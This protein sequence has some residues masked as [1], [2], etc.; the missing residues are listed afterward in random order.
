MYKPVVLVVLDG[1]GISNSIQGNPIRLASL[2]TIEKLDRF[3]PMT[4]LQASG[5]SVGLPWGETGNSEVGHMALGA[6]KIIYQNLPRITLAIQDQSFF[7]NSAFLEA[8]ENAKRMKSNLHLIGLFGEGSVHSYKDHVYALLELA[9]N[10]KMQDVYLHIFTDGRDSPPNS[11]TKSIKELLDK[12]RIFNVGKIASVC[13]RNWAMDRNNNWDRVEK[14]YLL[15]TEGKGEKITDPIKYLQESY[16]K[17]IFDEYIEPGVVTENGNPVAVIKD[18]DSVIF[19][20]FREDRARE[21][22][23]A[24]V[25]PEFAGFKRT[26]KLEIKFIT[27]IEY[28]KGLPVSTAFPPEEIREGL[29]EVLSKNNIAQLRIAETEKYA[30]VTYFF[31]GGREEPWPA[32]DRTLIPSPV[33][34]HFDETPEMSAPQITEKSVEAIESG[35]YGFIL[36]NYANPDMIGH[37]GNEKASIEAVQAVDK[38]LSVLI[39]SILKAGGC[40]ILTSDH[41][42]VEEIKNL[43]TGQTDTE[44]SGNPV[45]IWYITPDNHRNKD[46]DEI[47]RNQNEVGGLL[48]DVAPTI[49]EIM[50][51]KKPPAMNGESL[52]PILK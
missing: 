16:E 1:W 51:I 7:R 27:M 34:A 28:E 17:E 39:P 48:S 26:R 41:G 12:I 3:Y 46:S 45:P 35:K 2:P 10:E 9:R 38:S 33:A 15:L 13:G 18:G 6:G 22:T 21:I 44:H 14:T 11:A 31:N 49:L 36:I 30:H 8:F 40:L 50:N 20:N 29:G 25:L 24:F 23:R 52:L 32:E 19:F 5:I 4:A 43:H 37:T 47:V 42:N